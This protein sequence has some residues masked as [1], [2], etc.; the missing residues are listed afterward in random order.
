VGHSSPEAE[1]LT[2][3]GRGFLSSGL[4]FVGLLFVVYVLVVY[5]SLRDDGR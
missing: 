2:A 1:H 4:L 3:K 5:I